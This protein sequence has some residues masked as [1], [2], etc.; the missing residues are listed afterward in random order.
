M[1]K[2]FK[3]LTIIIRIIAFILLLFSF[4]VKSC[5]GQNY[6]DLMRIVGFGLIFVSYIIIY[7]MKKSPK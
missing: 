4:Y 7:M 6:C 3:I 2:F 5:Y 1:E